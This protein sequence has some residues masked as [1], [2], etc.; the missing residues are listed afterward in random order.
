M[1]DINIRIE[2]Q[3]KNIGLSIVKQS[4]T[5]NYNELY[6]K[7]SINGIELIGN[8]TNEDLGLNTTPENVVTKEELETA[9]ANK[10]DKGDYLTEETDPIYTADKPNIALKSEIPDVSN[11]VTSNDFEGR[12]SSKQDKGNYALKSEIPNLSNYATKTDLNSKQNKLS[13]AGTVR[14]PVYYDGSQLKAVTSLKAEMVYGSFLK[15][16]YYAH[17]PEMSDIHIIPFIYNDF[18][19]IDKKG[20]SYTVTRSDSG[21][22]GNPHNIFDAAPSFMHS[23][24]F[25][26]D[27]VWTVDIVCPTPL[28]Y[29]TL[30]YVDFGSPGFACSYAKIEA[31]HSVTGEWKT[32]LEKSDIE[33]PYVYCRCNSDDLGVNKFKFT[34]KNPLS[35]QQFRISSIGAISYKSAGIEETV[36]TRKG[37]TVFGDVIAPNITKMQNDV[38]GLKNS[39]GNIETALAEV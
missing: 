10:Q 23:R 34:F 39:I 38:D 37:G 29:G 17:H 5:D 21:E 19:F 1:T 22:I 32:V 24:G 36:L 26:A 30:L 9:L 13:A 25:T 15:E 7:P 20:G 11:F 12:L 14:V 28:T 18:A 35:A 31:Q 16:M 4:G 8:L 33:L 6:N 27:T 2:K 3:D